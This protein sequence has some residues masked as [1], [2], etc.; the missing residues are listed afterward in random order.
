M[1]NPTTAETPAPSP[2]PTTGPTPDAG[3]A[4]QKYAPSSPSPPP[5]DPRPRPTFDHPTPTYQ[6]EPGQHPSPPH[7]H[8]CPRPRTTAPQPPACHQR[9]PPP[10]NQ[11]T[12][13]QQPTP[14]QPPTTPKAI[15]AAPAY[16]IP[17]PHSCPSCF[18]GCQDANAEIAVAPSG[19]EVGLDGLGVRGTQVDHHVLADDRARKAPRSIR[20]SNVQISPSSF[21]HGCQLRLRIPHR[22]ADDIIW[23]AQPRSGPRDQAGRGRMAAHHTHH[24]PTIVVEVTATVCRTQQLLKHRPHRR[25]QR[26]DQHP[27]LGLRDRNML[28]PH[29][30]HHHRILGR[31]Q[32]SIT[33]RPRTS[34][35]RDSTPHHRTATAA[36]A[37][38]QRHH[39]HPPAISDRPPTQVR[40]DFP[41][42]T[43]PAGADPILDA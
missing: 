17:H 4:R 25:R 9:P 8:R 10:T 15:T 38:G 37:P 36:R 34:P 28:R 12:S 1:P 23:K 33:Q 6:P 14:G 3:P 42:G 7:R 29:Q 32:P 41:G 30:V 16:P 21:C 13:P 43:C 22:S 18:P 11:Q 19:F 20:I 26:L 5:P 31:G 40:P 2:A 39:N 27:M 24:Q 35:S